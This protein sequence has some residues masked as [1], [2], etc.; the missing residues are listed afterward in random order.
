M[1][2]RLKYPPMPRNAQR[3]AADMVEAARQISG[4]ELDYS[5]ES[6]EVVDQIIEGIRAEG[7]ALE[8]VAETIFGFGCYTGEV[9]V[10]AGH[11]R[12]DMATEEE[13]RFTAGPFLVREPDGSWHNPV[14]KAFHRFE[15]GP[16]DSLAYFYQVRTA[17]R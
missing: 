4:A 17:S 8:D 12:W 7:V 2:L 15:N 10:R 9:F 3:F 14:G 1:Q 6:L 16:E 11:G 13:Q 5:P